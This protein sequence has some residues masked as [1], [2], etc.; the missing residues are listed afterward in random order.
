MKH[1]ELTDKEYQE[2]MEIASRPYEPM[3]TVEEIEN[4]IE[5]EAN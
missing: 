5:T 2:I 1:D 4:M 3:P